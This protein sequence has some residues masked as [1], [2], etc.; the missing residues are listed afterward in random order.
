M[1]PP[2]KRSF[3]DEA[4]DVNLNDPCSDDEEEIYQ[5]GNSDDDWTEIKAAPK[6]GCL[7]NFTDCS[8]VFKAFIG[9]AL[10]GL[11]FAVLQSGI[12][13]AMVCIFLIATATDHCCGLIVKCKRIVI[14]NIIKE[15]IA[16]G[17]SKDEV[18]RQEE[19]LG[20]TLSFGRI[21][22]A[23]LGR[24][25]LLAVNVSV[26]VTQ[27]GFTIGYFIFMGN[28][29]RS[30]LKHFLIPHAALQNVTNATMIPTHK[31]TTKMWTTTA[32]TLTNGNTTLFNTTVLPLFSEFDNRTMTHFIYHHLKNAV[33]AVKDPLSQANLLEN[34]YLAFAVLLLIP[35]PLL[36]LIS[37]VRNLRKLG[38]VS[39]I[40]NASIT[41]AFALTAIYIVST[42][43]GIPHNLALVKQ[44]T[45]PIF[46]GQVTGAFEGI[47]TVIPIEG[48]MA[49]NRKKYPCFLHLSLFLLSGILGTFG[50][51]GY[52]A[53]GEK[54]CQ[55][56]TSN[57][58]GDV[59][60]ALQL[61]LFVGVLF[62]YP[63]QIYPCI[64][65]TE[66]IFI[67][68]R[69]WRAAKR[70]SYRA[71]NSK[72]LS[73]DEE[74]KLIDNDEKP[75]VDISPVKLKTWEGNLIRVFLI[76]CTACIALVFRSQFAYIAALTGSIG[77]S[78]LSYILPPIFH[79]SLRRHEMSKWVIA[80][81]IG[82]IV[83]GVVGGLMGMSVTI[84]EIVTA[85]SAGHPRHC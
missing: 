56:V 14:A 43:N 70:T 1:S 57:L 19:I 38:P 66:R 69:T 60:I 10:I 28:T 25:G 51:I 17:E 2:N 45:F 15:K 46:F 11:P 20:R 16:H 26:M 3:E 34:S 13:L 83:F 64:Q 7:R 65:I 41:G 44:K 55:I 40:A 12:V 21:G 80:K 4:S 59:A 73:K 58:H 49:E 63:L 9:S 5:K 53:Y 18:R 23:C 76:T 68:L 75:E 71:L 77:S 6:I 48:S 22:K 8:N 42:M 36:V 67:K 62:T 81:D 85:F 33:E 54:T 24:P 50:V 37:F 29:L 32:A 74:E 82:L 31:L 47:G 78:L 79:I 52:L 72:V 27:F 61:L 35:L 84:Q 39:V 30:V